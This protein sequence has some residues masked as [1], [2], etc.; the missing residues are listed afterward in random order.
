MFF[1]GKWGRQKRQETLHEKQTIITFKYK[2]LS[3]LCNL[4]LSWQLMFSDVKRLQPYL[5]TTLTER[6]VLT[7]LPGLTRRKAA[8]AHRCAALM[9]SAFLPV[10]GA[11]WTK[12]ESHLFF[13]RIYCCNYHNSAY[14]ATWQINGHDISIENLKQINTSEMKLLYPCRKL[15]A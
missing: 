13:N 6:F 3:I 10:T 5:P 8:S 9:T 11:S 1:R 14:M 12:S 15:S 2:T 7:W 4:V